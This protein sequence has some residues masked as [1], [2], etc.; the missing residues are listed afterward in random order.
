MLLGFAVPP[1][2]LSRSA[3]PKWRR[4]LMNIFDEPLMEPASCVNDRG[5]AK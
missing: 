4:I 1:D 2:G 5:M 3:G